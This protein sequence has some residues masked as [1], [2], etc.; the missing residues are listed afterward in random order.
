M[1]LCLFDYCGCSYHARTT[2]RPSFLPSQLCYL[3]ELSKLCFQISKVRTGKQRGALLLLMQ[4][5]GCLPP[6]LFICVLFWVPKF[7]DTE[8][9][10]FI[11]SIDWVFPLFFSTLLPL[12]LLEPVV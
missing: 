8:L 5:V 3:G 9:P 6:R 2:N 12:V 11:I 7:D 4:K 10:F 1:L